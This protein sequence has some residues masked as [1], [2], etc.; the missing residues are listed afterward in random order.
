[1]IPSIFTSLGYFDDKNEVLEVLR[2]IFANLKSGGAFLIEV[3]GKEILARIFQPTR[4]DIMVF[5]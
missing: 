3:M 5:L 2:N 1:M 4:S